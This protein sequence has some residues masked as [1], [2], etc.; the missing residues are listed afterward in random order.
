[1]NQQSF[2][3]KFTC[4]DDSTREVRVKD[5]RSSQM[6]S[7]LEA[8]G[9]EVPRNKDDREIL[10]IRSSRECPYL[11]V[12]SDVDQF[13]EEFERLAMIIWTI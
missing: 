7:I 9:L 1:M 5:M 3:E 12:R 13:I 10:L 8:Y 6:K 4:T 2:V 11:P